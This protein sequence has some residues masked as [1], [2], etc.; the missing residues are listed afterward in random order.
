MPLLFDGTNLAGCDDFHFIYFNPK[1]DTLC[2]YDMSENVTF[3]MGPRYYPRYYPP[4]Y[5]IDFPEMAPIK[6]CDMVKSIE[7]T[8]WATNEKSLLSKTGYFRNLE[9]LVVRYRESLKP[10]FHSPLFTSPAGKAYSMIDMMTKRAKY[11]YKFFSRR[12][13]RREIAAMPDIVFIITKA[14]AR[15]ILST[16]VST[17][18]FSG[19][20]AVMNKVVENRYQL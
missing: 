1:I 18:K 11:Y 9:R 16:G 19:T 5:D 15:F 7:F 13:R 14:D 17:L 20:R 6:E 3:F 10:Y 12:V 2:L 8:G 4:R